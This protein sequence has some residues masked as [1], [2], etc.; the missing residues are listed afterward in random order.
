M[1]ENCRIHTL[2]YEFLDYVKASNKNVS[3]FFCGVLSVIH[4]KIRATFVF[5]GE[6]EHA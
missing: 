4:D 3:S 5:R 2:K 6:Y 1:G